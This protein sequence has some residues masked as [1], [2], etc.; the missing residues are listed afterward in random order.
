MSWKRME[1]K[2]LFVAQFQKNRPKQA[3]KYNNIYVRNIPKNWSEDDI[4]KYFS[5]YGEIG[6]MIVRV[7]E[8]DKLKKELPEE[9]ENIFLNI[10]M[11][12]F[13]LNL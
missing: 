3:P 13:A 12:L 2:K 5:Q 8:A 11:P 6:S 9:K 10:N 4:K 7:P 1:W